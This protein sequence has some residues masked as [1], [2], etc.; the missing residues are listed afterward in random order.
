MTINPQNLVQGPATVYFGAFGATE[1]AD[2][3]AALIAAP[4]G[5]WTDVGGITDNTSVLFEDTLTYGDQGVDQLVMAVGG[6]L[7]KRE[8][9]V[10][11]ALAEATLA[12]MAVALNSLVTIATPASGIQTL[13]PIVTSSATQPTYTAILIDGWAPTLSTGAAA[14]RRVILRKSLTS[15]KLSLEYEKAKMAGYNCQ[16]TGYWIS[17]SITPYHIQDQTA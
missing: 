12:N 11:A 9:V 17:P 8:V 2:T 5:A 14:R 3:N 16:W 4:G 6:R 13:D 1:P 15:T 7:T 10:T